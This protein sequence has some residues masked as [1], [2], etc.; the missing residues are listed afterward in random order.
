MESLRILKVSNK[1]VKEKGAKPMIKHTGKMT[2]HDQLMNVL[3]DIANSFKPEGLVVQDVP[4]NVIS[5]S[6]A[7]ERG[8]IKPIDAIPD[9]VENKIEKNA[10]ALK[11]GPNEDAKVDSLEQLTTLNTGMGG[12]L[13]P[14]YANQRHNLELYL[15]GLKKIPALSIGPKVLQGENEMKTVKDMHHRD[16]KFVS[17]KT[18]FSESSLRHALGIA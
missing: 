6:G 16:A 11:K 10:E 18:P 14:S 8:A 4:K 2:E 15:K 1:P 12:F 7:D 13:T 5:S 9:R 17:G 3:N